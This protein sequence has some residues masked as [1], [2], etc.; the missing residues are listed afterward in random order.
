[1]TVII[2]V[3]L[4][5]PL[6]PQ[7]FWS[8]EKVLELVGRKA[9]LPPLGLITVAAL[10]PQEWKFKL[11]DP[12]VG[13]VTEEEWNWA[14]LIILSGM[15]VQ[16]EDF[17]KQIREAKQR[18]KRV[19]VGGAYPT[20]LPDEVQAVGADYLVLDEGE[21]TLNESKSQIVSVL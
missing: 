9:L 10:L 14:E 17:L 12:N 2:K 21:I 7:S 11:V 5:Y 6:F 16:K 8:F 15:M 4:I 18:S 1:M 3:L 19:A 13:E 20:S